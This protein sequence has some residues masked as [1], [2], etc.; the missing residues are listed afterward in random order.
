MIT[1]STQNW[2]YK[3]LSNRLVNVYHVLLDKSQINKIYHLLPQVKKITRQT[4][5]SLLI[6]FPS[7]YLLPLGLK[8]II[9]FFEQF[10]PGLET[11][12]YT[13]ELSGETKK[14]LKTWFLSFE[15][16]LALLLLHEY[17]LGE[18]HYLDSP[19]GGIQ[20]G[21]L[22]LVFKPR[23]A[24]I[25]E[26]VNEKNYSLRQKIEQNTAH[27]VRILAKRIQ[28]AQPGFEGLA[29]LSYLEEKT[30]I[31]AQDAAEMIARKAQKIKY[32]SVSDFFST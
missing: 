30:G 11:P 7:G 29:L 6:E 16:C 3:I 21:H 12:E 8:K 28:E 31:A 15:G 27:F 2:S 14:R 32:A 22:K 23:F 24:K 26:P 9:D 20:I 19:T 17:N 4:D 18:W 5:G 25:I 10:L 13:Y 1:Y